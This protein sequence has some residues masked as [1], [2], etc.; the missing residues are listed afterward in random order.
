MSISNNIS[1]EIT[2]EFWNNYRQLV[3][4]KVLPYQWS[5][6][7]DE[8]QYSTPK[9]PSSGQMSEPTRGHTLRNL[10]I[11]AG[12]KSG[13]HTGY[14]FQDSDLYKW[15]E[16]VAY[17]L[18][19]RH[20]NDLRTLADRLIDLIGMAQDKDGYLV[21]LFQIDAPKERFR[22]LRQSHELYTMGHYIEA[23]TA[24][25][26]STGNEKALLIA[27]GMADCIDV[28]FGP[29]DGKIHGVDG[30][31]EIEIALPRLYEVTGERRYLRLASFFIHERGQNPDFLDEQFHQ[32]P[33]GI[34]VLDDNRF[35]H[36]YY[37]IDKP[38]TQQESANGHAVRLIYLCIGAAMTGRLTNDTSLIQEA[39]KLWTDIVHRRMYITGQVGSTHQGEA[40]T[41][42]Y[43]L[44]NGTMYGESC[45]SVAMAMFARRM[46]QIDQRSEYADILEKELFNGAISGMSLD[47]SHFF[48]VNPLDADPEASRSN[49]DYAHV[50]THRAEWFGCACCPSNIARLV[51]SIDKYIYVVD[52]HNGMDIIYSHQ[53]IANRTKFDHGI[54]IDQQSDF[55]RTGE[56]RFEID[57]PEKAQ[58]SFAIRIPSWSQKHYTVVRDSQLITTKPYQGFVFIEIGPDDNHVSMSLTLDMEPKAMVA[59]STVRA[60]SYKVAFMRGPQVFC[61]EGVDN[62]QPLHRYRVT[63]EAL[64]SPSNEV[65][66][67]YQKD[68]LGGVM[69]LKVP[70]ELQENTSP[71]LYESY[72]SAQE[73]IDGRK[74]TM[75]LIPYYAWANRDEG[76]MSVWLHAD[77]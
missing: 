25:Y 8:R 49:P 55:P 2:S 31:P 72:D 9:D 29:E 76:A 40:F 67:K 44:P 41:Y 23:A 73:L 60:D 52:R 17:T 75:T 65:E 30:H 68:L 56:I 62:D 51:A 53:F 69:T 58:F 15:L 48:Y 36:A 59:S 39:Q 4:E 54:V 24:Y 37:Q 61:A 19:Y 12:L 50:L 35:D 18:K 1:V 21:T 71:N 46:L 70:C 57:N 10:E 16:A 3:A 64:R 22:R 11:A 6:M 5:V 20:D 27:R 7:A 38:F 28:H 74:S 26:R 63:H 33:S 66:T 43:D 42:D 32:G 34:P 14:Q 47:G 45:A 13:H 77:L